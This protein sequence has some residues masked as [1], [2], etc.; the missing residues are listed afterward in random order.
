MPQIKW[1]LTDKTNKQRNISRDIEIKNKLTV[2]REEMGGDN[3]GEGEK[4][5]QGTCIKD[6]WTKPKGVRIEGGRWGWLG[7]E[8]VRGKWRQLYLNNN[9]KNVKKKNIVISVILGDDD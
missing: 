3:G 1:N 2:T 4:G 9:K 5:C 8:V 6:T 7:Q